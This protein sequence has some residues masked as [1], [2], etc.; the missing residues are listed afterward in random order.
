[1]INKSPVIVII[2]TG[3]GKSLCFMLPAANCP[4]GVTVVVVLLVSLLGDIVLRCR[5]LG[6][7]CAELGLEF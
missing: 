2:G 5:K 1:M 4:G 3:G 7:I 6:I